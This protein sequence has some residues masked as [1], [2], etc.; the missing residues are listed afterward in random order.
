M[1]SIGIASR[2][3]ELMLLRVTDPVRV[4]FGKAFYEHGTIIAGIAQSRMEIDQA[5]LLVLSAA[6][7]VSLLGLQEEEGSGDA[8]GN[9]TTDRLGSR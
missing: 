1:R 4:T 7:Q 3:L 9:Q 5:R 2:A 8:D 6:L